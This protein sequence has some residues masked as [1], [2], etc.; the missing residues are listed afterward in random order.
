MKKFTPSEKD[1]S[2]LSPWQK[3]NLK[4][5]KKHQQ[6]NFNPTDKKEVAGETK[7]DS[8]NHDLF[9]KEDTPPETTVIKRYIKPTEMDDMD[10][11]DFNHFEEWN[12]EPWDSTNETKPKSVT[13]DIDKKNKIDTSFDE[14]PTLKLLSNDVQSEDI[15]DQEKQWLDDFDDEEEESRLKEWWNQ[16]RSKKREPVLPRKVRYQLYAAITILTIA[17][18][19]TFY[20]MTPLSSLGK[21]NV[22]GNSTL[23]EQEVIKTSQFKTGQ[24]LWHQ[25]F[26]K[27]KAIQRIDRLPGVK[28]VT[29]SLDH[30]NQFTIHMTEYPIVGYVS[31]DKIKYSPV[32]SDG[33]I[34]TSHIAKKKPMGILYTGFKQGKYLSSVIQAYQKVPANVRKLVT[35]ITSTPSKS[36][37]Q[38]VTI[39]MKD[40]NQVKIDGLKMEKLKYYPQIAS[41]MD[42]TGVVDMEVGIYSYPYGNDDMDRKARNQKNVAD[43]TVVNATQTSTTQSS[44]QEIVIPD[45]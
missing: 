12:P 26:A 15:S 31:V 1:E 21:V 9:S 6:N 19:I 7:I 45:N 13:E 30:L 41:Q 27:N 4:F 16:L 42:N 22:V 34:V 11:D 35:Q 38:L 43:G 28:R 29:I 39:Y 33:T 5:L 32:L 24:R 36:N 37:K 23:S 25:Y 10:L 2:S 14:G 40:G 44:T 3:E 20:Y 18:S 8:D 17:L